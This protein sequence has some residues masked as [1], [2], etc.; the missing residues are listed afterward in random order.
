M[1]KFSKYVG[2]DTHKDTIAV[3]VTEACGG[4]ARYFGEIANTPAAI[5]KL[6]K[7]LSPEGEV[8]SY[9]YEAGPCGYGLYRQ[10]TE[11]GHECSVVAPS[12]FDYS[13]ADTNLHCSKCPLVPHSAA[14]CSPSS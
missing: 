13:T 9:C 14:A 6:M 1:E 5:R 10:I 8:V 2:L 11:S 7:R 3:G 12:A 4:S